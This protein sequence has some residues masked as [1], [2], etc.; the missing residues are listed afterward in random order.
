MGGN[1]KTVDFLVLVG[2]RFR[3]PRRKAGRYGSTSV[4][5]IRNEEDLIT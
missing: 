4:V 3:G 5:C 1:G 2:L